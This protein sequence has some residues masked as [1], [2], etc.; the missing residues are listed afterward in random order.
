MQRQGLSF[1]DVDD[2]TEDTDDVTAT[3]ER[4]CA[5][6]RFD[7]LTLGVQEHAAVVRSFRWAEQ[8]AHEDLVPST[9]FFRRKH[10]GQVPT[11]NIADNALRGAVDPADD[12]G[13]VDHV[14]RDA[15][16]LMRPFQISVECCVQSGD[17]RKCARSALQT[18]NR[19]D[20]TTAD[21][22][23]RIHAGSALY[24]SA[25]QTARRAV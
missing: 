13:S 2:L 19:R 14:R 21:D 1:V 8:I 24:P 23:A 20:R 11:A 25:S 12:P 10:R 5:Q 3:F 9:S 7:S 6:F 15:G 18:S 4:D 22:D 17:G 16:T